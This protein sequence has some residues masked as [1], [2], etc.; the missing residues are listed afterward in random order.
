M[1]CNLAVSVNI[2]NL[3]ILLINPPF[4]EEHALF[5]KN[6]TDLGFQPIPIGLI[7]IS[8]SLK[9]AQISVDIVNFTNPKYV[10]WSDVELFLSS[11]KKYGFIGITCYTRQRFSIHKLI[12]ICHITHPDAKII[13]GG[14]HVS[15]LSEVYFDRFKNISCIISGEG[16]E[17][18]VEY[19]KMVSEDREEIL[20]GVSYRKSDGTIQYNNEVRLNYNIN[21]IL[22]I[23]DIKYLNDF[24]T[25]ENLQ[26]HLKNISDSFTKNTIENGKKM[27]PILCSR[28]CRGICL[29][30]S[31][32]SFSKSNQRY[33]S[34]SNV[35]S[36]ILY[37]YNNGI[38]FF[39]FYDD[40]L[41]DNNHFV[42]LLCEIILKSNLNISWW[43]SSRVDTINRNLLRKMKDAGCFKISYGV[44][45]GSQQILNKIN[46]GITIKQIKETFTITKE[47]GL[48]VRA[49]ISIGHISEN[50]DTIQETVELLNEI[51]PDNLGLFILNIYPGTRLFYYSINKGYIDDT[52][53]FDPN[54]GLSPFFAFETNLLTL[55]KFQDYIIKNLKAKKIVHDGGDINDG[56]VQYE[57][58]WD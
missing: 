45:S 33:Y 6:K 10:S 44:E 9:N 34:V 29:F 55:L 30:C 40:N 11:S 52:Y 7:V 53:W 36:E 15:F 5:T 51:K 17:A 14:P 24:E 8:K 32:S 16:E 43:C 47:E 2:M 48:L 19:I 35:Y 58:E 25:V 4:L 54:N 26:M 13:L 31:N 23:Y 39:D 38:R 50:W 27:A 42:Q 28:G 37:Y 49:T 56:N 22:P 46:K 3:N 18:I 1:L 12:D 57:I 41:T 20:K 21:N